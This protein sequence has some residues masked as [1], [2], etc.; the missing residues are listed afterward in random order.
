MREYLRLIIV[1]AIIC[2]MAGGALT[3]VN[4]F[5]EPKIQALKIQ[6][7]SD[8]YQQALPIADRFEDAPEAFEQTKISPA[9]NLI[10]NVKAGLKDGTVV[11]W[12]CKVVT[13]GY[14]GNIDMLIGI[15]KD[16]QM[17]KVM[18]LGHTE[19]PGLGSNITDDQFIGQAAIENA[20]AS[21]TLQVSKDGGSVQAITGATVSS[22]AVLRGINQVFWLQR[23][24][25]GQMVDDSIDAVSDA[26][27]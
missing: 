27:M 9:L 8:A 19:T 1:L 15:K 3:L 17:G 13:S 22:R 18:V 2:A 21:Q 7:E 6:T 11:G 10:Q 12:V 5:T 14:G 23:R 20:T 16:G 24:L 4:T 26:S 25:S